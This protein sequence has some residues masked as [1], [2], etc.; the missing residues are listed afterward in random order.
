MCAGCAVSGISNLVGVDIAQ[1]ALVCSAIMSV[2]LDVLSGHP[3][4]VRPFPLIPFII[5]HCDMDSLPTCKGCPTN[6]WSGAALSSANRQDV[7]RRQI[8]RL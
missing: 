2:I 4:I 3:P 5:G 7:G 1:W 8:R 6:W